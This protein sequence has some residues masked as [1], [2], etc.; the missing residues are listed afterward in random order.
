MVGSDLELASIAYELEPFGSRMWVE[1]QELKNKLLDKASLEH[2]F[3]NEL[4][5]FDQKDW[6]ISK[7]YYNHTDY[8]QIYC[9]GKPSDYSIKI[10]IDPNNNLTEFFQHLTS[11][12]DM[13]E[14]AE[15]GDY[16]LVGVSVS[17]REL[18]DSIPSFQ[19]YN[20]PFDKN[21]LNIE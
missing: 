7:Q 20:P 8:N 21:L 12:R 4:Y 3:A 13:L 10:T 16:E 18:K 11:L 15:P 9:V 2:N 17:I 6:E 14:G 1:S 19:V 5:G